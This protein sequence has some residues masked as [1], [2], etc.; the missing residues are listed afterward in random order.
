MDAEI[1]HFNNTFPDV[2]NN[3]NLSQYFTVKTFNNQFNDLNKIDLSILHLN[4]RS[5]AA[6]GDDFISYIETL[7]VKFDIICLSETWLNDSNVIDNHFFPLYNSYHSFRPAGK[8]GGGVSIFV[9]KNH[10]S[11]NLLHLSSN[12]ESIECVF[13]QLKNG[14][15]YIKVG[16]VYRPPYNNHDDFLFQY[17]NKLTSLNPN[18]SS[19]IICGD[20]NYDLF[21]ISQDHKSANFYEHSSSISFIPTIHKP[22]RITNQTF[23]LIDNIFVNNLNNFHS[24]LFSYDVSDHVPI[25]LVYKSI[26]TENVILPVTYQI[27]NMSS[28]H[29]S[30]LYETFDAIDFGYLE[31]LDCDDAV[32]QLHLKILT[33]YNNCCPIKNK[34]KSHKDTIKPWINPSIKALIKKRQNLF[35]LQ[36]QNKISTVAYNR[37]RNLVTSKIRTAKKTYFQNLFNDIKKDT[38]KTWSIINEIIRPNCNKNASEIKSII[39]N[40]SLIIQP[41]TIA[42]IFNS[43]FPFVGKII[44]DAFS[45]GNHFQNFAIQNSPV[46]SFF[47]SYVNNEDVRNII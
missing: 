36:R 27:R 25:F 41:N 23:S 30:N 2:F 14:D 16:C 39:H 22:T 12:E 15:S 8:R 9:L 4:I 44:S 37:F 5:L 10:L 1:N 32:K 11:E 13:V 35:M 3:D 18:N 47:F 43:Y 28:S 26:L 33:S 46:N 40:D 21:K 34:T 45:N 24:G 20:F 19:C 7:D 38:K 17:E 6:N 29:L 31:G 42:S